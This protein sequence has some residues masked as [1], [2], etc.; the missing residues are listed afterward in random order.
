M[1]LL[2]MLG[3]LFLENMSPSCVAHTIHTPHF[4][5]HKLNVPTNTAAIFQHLLKNVA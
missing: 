2:V 4:M 1:L 3:V 5:V